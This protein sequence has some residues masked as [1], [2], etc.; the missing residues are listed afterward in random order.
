MTQCSWQALDR[1]SAF[2]RCCGQVQRVVDGPPL[3]ERHWRAMDD[4]VEPAKAAPVLYVM[5]TPDVIKVGFS[6]D[7]KGRLRALRASSNATITPEVDVSNLRLLHAARS[8]PA[9]EA[10]LHAALAPSRAV[11][12][13]FHRSE[14]VENFLS[15]IPSR[16]AWSDPHP[17]AEPWVPG[18]PVR[19]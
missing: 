16:L 4:S 3:C 5:G 2:T 8:V 15:L 10:L 13:W 6:S 1:Y 9:A 11:G 7:P 12:E 17:V 19:L 18:M 14:A